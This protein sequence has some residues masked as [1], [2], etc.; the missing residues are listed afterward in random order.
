MRTVI[1]KHGD[2]TFPV[3]QIDDVMRERGKSLTFDY[4]ELKD[5]VEAKDRS[6]PLLAFLYPFVNIRDNVMHVDHVFSEG[7]LYAEPVTEGRSVGR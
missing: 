5:L 7:T 1:G 6:F 4:E 2:S 3:R